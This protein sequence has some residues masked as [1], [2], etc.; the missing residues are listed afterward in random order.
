MSATTIRFNNANRSFY[1]AAKKR[2]DDYFKTNNISRYG[3]YRMVLKSIFMFTLYFTPFILLLTNVF[4]SFWAQS[5]MWLLMGLGMSGIGLS[6]MHDA[7]HGSYARNATLNALMCRS[8]NFIGGSSINWQ[9]QHNT[10]HH[11]YTNI[12]E[13]DEDIAPPGFLRFSPN[14]PL[15]K[16]HKLQFI[17][18]WFFY[19]L[20]TIMWAT[21]KDFKQLNRYNKMGLLAIKKT[22]YKVELFKLIL[23][24]IFYLSYS[25][26]LPMVLMNTHWYLVL[27]GWLIMHYLCGMILALIFQPA[28]VIEDTTFPL[29]DA[30]GNME[31]D[32]ATHQL[33]TTL[34]FAQK[35]WLFSWF[36]GGLNFQV[37]HHLFP[38]ICHIH[39][40]KIAPLIKQTAE[41]F[42]LPYYT[43]KTFV[44]AVAGHA[45]LLY[46]LGR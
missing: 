14:T 40:K 21:T 43:K 10:L 11:T 44:G 13:H 30:N 18:A 32:W 46:A 4:D 15:K 36:V 8:M 23:N 9:L 24:K 33:K 31:D 28:H 7:N 25:L 39:Y 5:I 17:Y 3:D 1:L 37:E 38:N 2:V 41:E 34:D 19:G 16:V 45:K 12:D 26:A 35:S 42:N 6:I 29:P 22:T 27:A 20:M